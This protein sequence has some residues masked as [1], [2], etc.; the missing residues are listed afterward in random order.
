MVC[1]LI[2]PLIWINL[3]VCRCADMWRR[4][5]V[6]FRYCSSVII[7]FAF[8][9]KLTHL[10][11]AHVCLGVCVCTPC[12]QVPGL[13]V[14]VHPMLYRCLESQKEELNFLELDLQIVAC[15][16]MW[17]LGTKP[18]SFS[19]APN[20]VNWWAI[21]P[22]LILCFETGPLTG[23]LNLQTQLGWL[24]SNLHSPIS[25]PLAPVIKKTTHDDALFFFM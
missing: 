1:L 3:C 24:T 17:V 20:A 8:I 14:C 23:I 13:G 15:L 2:Y 5:E 12:L 7:N 9:F 18:R 4:P 19:R 21:S 11:C 22:A 6:N 25:A 16:L 10:V